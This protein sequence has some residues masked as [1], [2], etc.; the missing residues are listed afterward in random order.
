[1]LYIAEPKSASTSLVVS[2]AKILNIK[3]SNGRNKVKGDIKCKG[4]ESIQSYHNTTVFRNEAF[5]KKYLESTN[6]I[7]KEHILPVKEHIEVIEK[8]KKPVIVSIRNSD[9]IIES[10]K[11]VF[12]VLPKIDQK[13]DYIKLKEELNYFANFYLN[14]QKEN[15]ELWL[16]ITFEDIIFNFEETMKKII[17]HYGFE[18][19]DKEIK[20]HQLEK[21]NC[22]EHG[23]R[24]L[25]K[26]GFVYD[27]LRD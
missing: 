26:E 10:Y 14:K 24:K 12:S 9:D 20:K 25:I 21:R 2:I 16:V 8:I 7:L 18:V 15:K 22:T 17:K 1:M 3:F 19:K 4:F 23:M 27:K 13:M 5:L 11:R 6:F